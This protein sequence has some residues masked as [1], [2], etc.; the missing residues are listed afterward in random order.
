MCVSFEQERNGLMYQSIP[1]L[2]TLHSP[3]QTPEQLFE[4]ANFPPPGNKESARL[5][6]LGQKIV[7]KPHSGAIIFNN[8]TKKTKHNTEI[9]K[10]VPTC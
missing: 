9:M 7:L 5:R 4:R 1:I 8:P 3:G 6:T 2:T 10:T